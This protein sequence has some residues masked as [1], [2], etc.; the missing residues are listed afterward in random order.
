LFRAWV[1]TVVA[2]GG[3]ED[4]AIAP[5]SGAAPPEPVEHAACVEFGA[6]GML[7]PAHLEGTLAGADVA[8]PASCLV[9]N[10]PFGAESAGPDRVIPL[11]GL[12]AGTSYVVKLTSA[13]DLQFYV[14]TGCAT[15]AGP[16]ADQCLLFEDSSLDSIEVGRFVAGGS[17]AYVVVDYFASHTPP[18]PSFTLDVYE[19]ECED[20]GQCGGGTPACSDGRCVECVSSFDCADADEPRCEVASHTCTAG[21]T[22]GYGDDGADPSDDGPSGA[23][24][25]VLDTTGRASAA[26]TM[27]AS[28]VPL[29]PRLA[30]EADFVAFDVTTL[31]ETWDFQLGWSGGRDLDFE[32]LDGTGALLGMSFWE[33][34]ERG[35][36]TYLPVGRYY[37]RVSEFASSPD[38]APV[39]YTLLAQ[40]TLGAACTSAADCASE[41]RNQIF[42][43]RCDAGACVRIDGGGAIGE[44]GACDSQSDCGLALH[45]PSFFFMADA[46]TRETCS[47]SCGD[48]SDCLPGFAC[49]TYLANN[50]CVAKCTSDAQCPTAPTSPPETGPWFRLSCDVPS[51]HCLP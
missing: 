8:S 4:V 43:G 31:G 33:H 1:L 22:C 25:L 34:P 26:G 40:R 18:S 10:A 36:L 51:G 32:V 11:R 28:L 47:A 35:R 20:A 27:C 37:V 3:S 44:G 39:S 23:R 29:G 21:D 5:D 42:R 45:C 48:D 7:V 50:F 6:Q 46:D 19:E 13:S 49:T 16:G 38:P 41:F 17:S 24:V 12:R 30:S 15:P 9:M 14:T 2:C